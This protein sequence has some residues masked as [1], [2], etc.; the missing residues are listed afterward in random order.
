[1]YIKFSFLSRILRT[2]PRLNA[3][4]ELYPTANG[5]ANCSTLCQAPWVPPQSLHL[6]QE[7]QLEGNDL[8]VFLVSMLLITSSRAQTALESTLTASLNYNSN[9][10]V[11]GHQRYNAI[12]R[13]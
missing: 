6:L 2:L 3:H 7:V 1:M 11:N 13:F 4:G 10:T 5:A 8:Y 9:T 12:A